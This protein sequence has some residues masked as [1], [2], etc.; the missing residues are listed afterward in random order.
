MKQKRIAL[1]DPLWRANIGIV[2]GPSN[3]EMVTNWFQHH[4]IEYPIRGGA[5]DGRTATLDAGLNIYIFLAPDLPLAEF[6]ATLAHE[7]FHAAH[8]ILS[9]RGQPNEDQDGEE[10]HAY[11]ISWIVRSV[12]NAMNPVTPAKKRK[13]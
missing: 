6:Y 11:F 7:A 1:Y 9:N 2:I 8:M 13:R 10:S 3:A 5:F 12:T 4:G